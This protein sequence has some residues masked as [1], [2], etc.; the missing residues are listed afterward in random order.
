MYNWKK[1][2]LNRK[3]IVIGAVCGISIVIGL[4]IYYTSNSSRKSKQKSKSKV[5][6]AYIRQE[7]KT[8]DINEQ[9]PLN[10]LESLE[11]QSKAIREHE[12]SNEEKAAI[13]VPS[14]MVLNQNN[15]GYNMQSIPG[16]QSDVSSTLETINEIQS[17]NAQ[18]VIP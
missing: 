3:N 4:W 12:L 13:I 18:N 15:K 14:T 8:A 10:D 1:R 16:S 7:Q 9:K 17:I 6:A 11:I 5:S 2:L